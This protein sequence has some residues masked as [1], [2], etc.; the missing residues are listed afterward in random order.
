MP[1]P[2]VLPHPGVRG[3]PLSYYSFFYLP[4]MTH[5]HLHESVNTCFAADPTYSGVQK[6]LTP[7]P[8]SPLKATVENSLLPW[9]PHHGH[10]W[11]NKGGRDYLPVGW[12]IMDASLFPMNEAPNQL[13]RIPLLGQPLRLI[14]HS[15]LFL[16]R[17]TV[18]K[19]PNVGWL[20]VG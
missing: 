3:P 10:A 18:W 5:T 8:P 9:S 2:S 15:A 6:I 4:H 1:K 14:P 13:R 16:L 11:Q 19:V 17:L 20:M 7:S 12:G